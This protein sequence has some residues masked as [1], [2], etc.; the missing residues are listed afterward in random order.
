MQNPAREADSFSA[1]QYIPS[2]LGS[3]T[4]HYEYFDDL[5]CKNILSL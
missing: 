3:H 5:S 2:I 1:I 4:G